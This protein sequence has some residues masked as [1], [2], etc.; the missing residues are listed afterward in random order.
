MNVYGRADEII[1][2]LLR[3]TAK[4][5][6][7]TKRRLSSASSSLAAFDEI[8]L[9][10]AEVDDLATDAYI[11]IAN[12]GYDQ[13]SPGKRPERIDLDW[14]FY[15]EGLY[16]P[17]TEYVYYNE[18]DRQKE[19]LKEA[20]MSAIERARNGTE[21]TDASGDRVTLVAD[22][23]RLF[24]KAYNRLAHM[25]QQ[26][27][28][29]FLD[30]GRLDAMED[31]GVQKVMWNATPDERTCAEC[32]ALDGEIFPITQIPDKHWG[33]RCWLTKA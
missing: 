7:A 2:R 12:D 33:C 4:K 17:T 10:F 29:R 32:N 20:V 14:I 21:R 22:I 16:D 11:A 15:V 3:E 26:F 24:D 23:K 13:V 1:Y 28:I 27:A 5:F 31:D 18:Y 8:N 19:S 30:L 9:L 25:F 6:N